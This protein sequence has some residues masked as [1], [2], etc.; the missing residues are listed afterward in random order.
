MFQ[1]TFASAHFYLAKIRHYFAPFIY[2]FSEICMLLLSSPNDYQ[3]LSPPHFFQNIRPPAHALCMLWGVMINV[4]PNIYH[5]I[6]FKNLRGL[7]LD[8]AC[9]CSYV[10]RKIFKI[11]FLRKPYCH[12]TSDGRLRLPPLVNALSLSLRAC[13]SLTLS[14]K[15]H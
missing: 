4:F 2:F 5:L 6:F 11:N 9:K 13:H 8:R 1:N 15:F 10:L 12:I 7:T 14:H 3:S